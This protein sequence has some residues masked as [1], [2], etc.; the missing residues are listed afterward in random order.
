MNPEK[1]RDII[2]RGEDSSHQFKQKLTS[3]DSLAAE[4]VAFLNAKGGLIIVGVD[5]KGTITGL[6]TSDIQ[7]INQTVSN[8]CNDWIKPLAGAT[9]ENHEID[10]NKVVCISVPQGLDRPYADKDGHYW[11]KVGADKRKLGREELQ[12]MFQ[13]SEKFYADEQVVHRSQ[14]EDIDQ[15]LFKKLY[16]KTTQQ[17]LEEASLSHELLLRNMNLA[18]ANHLTLAGV[19]LLSKA[20]SKYPRPYFEIR[21]VSFV[22]D[23]PT[24]ETYR[25]TETIQGN[26]H[27]LYEKGMAFFFRN[28]QKIQTTD[29]FN[30]EG[31][32]EV[33]R[34]ALEEL[35]IN[36]LIH[37]NYFIDAP[38][39]L[40]IFD[41]RI[42]IISPGKL[43]NSLTIDNIKSG[44]S[45]PRNP[46]VHSYGTKLLPY[47]GVGTGISRAI[48]EYP[49]LDLT[50]DEEKELFI[51]T[52]PR[53]RYTNKAKIRLI[54][55]DDK[56]PD[57]PSWISADEY[58][59]AFLYHVETEEKICRLYFYSNLLDAFAYPSKTDPVS[60]IES[61]IDQNKLV[62]GSTYAFN[63]ETKSWEEKKR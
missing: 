37:R 5:D 12:R 25:D 24:V 41:N 60:F 28:L 34:I 48:N 16:L 38:I 21:A 33:S 46:V 30:T 31:T 49:A 19:L 2:S 1:L 53:P 4:I 45:H 36:A 51:V 27:H 11:V 59:H 61:L 8:V 56:L 54:R 62:S 40:F 58:T 29:N 14:I 15:E 20:I 52:L 13:E 17:E 22:G 10:G 6:E 57:K 42:E 18:E 55:V 32:L 26:L 43:P 7:R 3:P 23:S 47:R 50:N 9:T 63:T 35:L 39:R 44:N